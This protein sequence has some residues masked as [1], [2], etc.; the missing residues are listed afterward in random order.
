MAEASE[1]DL[2]LGLLHKRKPFDLW[3]SGS[4]LS[5]DAA[6]DKWVAWFH[7]SR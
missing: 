5:Y 4:P 7:G 3:L 2:L 6:A 1:A